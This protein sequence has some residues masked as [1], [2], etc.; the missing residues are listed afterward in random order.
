MRRIIFSA[1]L[2]CT[3]S[4]DAQTVVPVSIMDYMR[5]LMFGRNIPETDSTT[6]KKWFV[7]SSAGISTSISFFKGGHA[8]AIAVPL[9]LQLNRRLNNNWYAFAAVS[10]APAY[11]NMF[12]NYGVPGK[13]SSSSNFMQPGNLGIYSRAE[14]GLM[15]V[16]DAKT[17]SISGS[18]GI[19][20]N[21][22]GSMAG[23]P[24][25]TVRPNPALPRKR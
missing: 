22:Y 4:V 11:I 23:F 13:L 21:N 8:T 12:G 19:E 18:I 9:T 25:N 14:L 2:I 16:N 24:V 5:P 7:T 1:L 6:N 3:I 10:A 17:F 20:K 15:Y